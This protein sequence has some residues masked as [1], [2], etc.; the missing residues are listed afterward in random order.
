MARVPL[1]IDPYPQEELVEAYRILSEE[2]GEDWNPERHIGTIHY[3]TASRTCTFVPEIFW[4][5]RKLF[6]Q[7]E[8]IGTEDKII[9]A[10]EHDE[11]R[12][13]YSRR[14]LFWM[15]AVCRAHRN[16]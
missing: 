6:P 2:F 15:E 5:E 9:S 11:A 12:N 13:A 16:G 14:L 3:A 7:G 8:W 4:V 10:R 1:Y